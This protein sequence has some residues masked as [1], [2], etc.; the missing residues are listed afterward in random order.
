MDAAKRLRPAALNDEHLR[1]TYTAR[2]K[3][4][5]DARWNGDKKTKVSQVAKFDTPIDEAT[6]PDA[7]K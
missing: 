1:Q 7:D 2:G 6:N 5:A 4:A 3:K